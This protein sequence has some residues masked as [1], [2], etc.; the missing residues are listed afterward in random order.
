MKKEL[1]LVHI[2]F[3]SGNDVPQKSEASGLDRFLS[4]IVSNIILF[5]QQNRPTHNNLLLLVHVNDCIMHLKFAFFDFSVHGFL[6]TLEHLSLF[7]VN[8][9]CIF[10]FYLARFFCQGKDRNGLNPSV[11]TIFF[12]HFVTG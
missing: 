11:K 4:L 8:F 9:F 5:V 6:T 12:S 2:I 1:H 3:L 10:I 7:F